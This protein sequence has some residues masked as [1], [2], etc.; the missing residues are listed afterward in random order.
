MLHSDYF[1]D[2]AT[3]ANIFLR[4]YRMSKELFMEILHGV[5]E[6]D[7]YFKMKHNAVGTDGF[8]LIQKCIAAMRMLA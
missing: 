8:S 4:R 7:S 5:R 1:S 2:T 3:H 6:F